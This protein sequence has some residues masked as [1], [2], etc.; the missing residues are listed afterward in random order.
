MTLMGCTQ[1]P[2]TRFLSKPVASYLLHF[3]LTCTLFYD[4]VVFV[5]LKKNTKIH[6]FRKKR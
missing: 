1:H 2:T 3:M 4:V 6:R 5:S